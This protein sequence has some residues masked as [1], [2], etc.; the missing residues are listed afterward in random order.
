MQYLS[1]T[2]WVAR[3]CFIISLIAGVL[4]VYFAVLLQRIIGAL[5]GAEDVKEWLST[6]DTFAGANYIHD[7]LRKIENACAIAAGSIAQEEYHR[8][9]SELDVVVDNSFWGN[10]AASGSLWSAQMLATPTSLINV[11]LSSFLTGLAVYLGFLWTRSLD[12]NAGPNDSR[13]VFI[14]FLISVTLCLFAYAMPRGFKNRETI[15]FQSYR[16]LQVSL[17]SLKNNLKEMVME[18]QSNSPR[19][20]GSFPT[21]APEREDPTQPAQAAGAV[22]RNSGDIIIPISTSRSTYQPAANDMEATNQSTVRSSIEVDQ[23]NGI[24]SSVINATNRVTNATADSTLISALQEAAR[25]H[26]ASANADRLV[27]EAYQQLLHNVNK[28]GNND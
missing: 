5:Y 10:S 8:F 22:P 26:E 9:C 21:S 15:P 13:N 6:R 7:T 20:P 14:I 1:Q 28:R 18:Q 12:T 2:H 25:A 3:A 23:S 4:S 11:S 19:G 16:Y 24:V 17:K 27:A